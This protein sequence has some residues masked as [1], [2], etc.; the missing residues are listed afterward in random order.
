MKRLAYAFYCHYPLP[1]TTGHTCYPINVEEETDFHLAVQKY[2]SWDQN[3]YSREATKLPKK[4]IH[5]SEKIVILQLGHLRKNLLP[6]NWGV[7]L[8]SDS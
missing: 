7:K 4:E 1:A 8:S 3:I 6:N 2:W 5:I